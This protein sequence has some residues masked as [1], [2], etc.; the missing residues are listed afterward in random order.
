MAPDAVRTARASA[1]PRRRLSAPACSRPCRRRRSG[2]RARPCRPR[3]PGAGA[4]WSRTLRSA[5]RSGRPSRGRR[6]SGRAWAR[7]EGAKNWLGASWPAGADREPDHGL[8]Q[9]RRRRARRRRATARRR[10]RSRA[11][12]GRARPRRGP[13]PLCQMPASELSSVPTPDSS[14]HIVRQRAGRGAV[15]GDDAAVGRDVAVGR[16]RDVDDAVQQQQPGPLHREVFVERDARACCTGVPEICT[17]KPGRSSP[18]AAEIAC[19]YQREP[20]IPLPT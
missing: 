15:A 16:E 13:P 4:L 18:V 9:R 7:R 17:G 11:R 20:A 2:T 12:S 14:L 5:A 8:R 6:R 1:A 10:C 19:R 3:R